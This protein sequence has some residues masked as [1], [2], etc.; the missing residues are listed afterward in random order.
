VLQCR[1]LWL[2]LRAASKDVA[3]AA[4]ARNQRDRHGA[5][6]IASHNFVT[7]VS[8]FL[9]AFRLMLTPA[10]SLNAKLPSASEF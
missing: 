6:I 3:Q 5:T 8:Q 7:Y 4:T 9:D 2:K 10:A 1:R